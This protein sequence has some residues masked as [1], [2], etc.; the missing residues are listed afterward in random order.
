MER[1]YLSFPLYFDVKI[2]CRFRSIMSSPLFALPHASVERHHPIRLLY[3][4]NSILVPTFN[5]V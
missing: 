3:R 2:N 5:V 1:E 4:V